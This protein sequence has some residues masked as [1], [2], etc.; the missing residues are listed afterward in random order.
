MS[1]Y[2][3]RIFAICNPIMTRP[4]PKVKVESKPAT[5][6]PEA[7]QEAPVVEEPTDD[8][9]MATVEELPTDENGKPME[10]DDID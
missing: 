5:P 10:V 1:N 4:A 6:A 9:D 8:A 3:I 7:E 2:A